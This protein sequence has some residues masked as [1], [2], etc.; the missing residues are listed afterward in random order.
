MLG[1]IQRLYAVEKTARPLTASQRAALRQ[2]KAAPILAEIRR[3]LQAW[4]IEALP[5]SPVGLAVAYALGQWTALTRYV[6]DGRLQIDNNAAERALR[7][8]AVGRKNWLFAGSDEGGRRAAILYSLIGSCKM[9]KIDPWAYLTDVLERISTH[10]A[11][12][13]AELTP[14]AWKAARTRLTP[15]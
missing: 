14:L 9:A 8:V 7:M 11:S 10:P 12:R 3:T 15:A 1:L 2:Q 6:E 5:K 13:I 4:S